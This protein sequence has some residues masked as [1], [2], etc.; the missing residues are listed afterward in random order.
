MPSD[1]KITVLTAVY[2]GERYMREAIDSILNQTYKNFEYILVDNNSTDNTPKILSDYAQRDERIKIVKET[3]QSPAYARNAGLQVATGEW[4]AIFDADDVSHPERLERQYNYMI[5]HPNCFF[6][7]TEG[8]MIGETGKKLKDIRIDFK[9]LS[10]KDYV[11][12]YGPPFIHS[13]MMFSKQKVLEFGGYNE[14]YKTVEDLELWLKI[15]YSGIEINVLRESLINYRYHP[16]SL[17]HKSIESLYLSV[18]TKALYRAKDLGNIN[19]NSKEI[20]SMVKRDSAI[21]SYVQSVI[22]RKKLKTMIDCFI[23][24]DSIKGIALFTSLVFR[25]HPALLKP[26][27]LMPIIDALLNKIKTLD[28]NR[29]N[30][31]TTS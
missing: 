9:G 27:Q 17:S 16:K 13:S 11:L 21:N 6:L 30:D 7:A 2:N 31:D 28:G 5:S 24:G 25:L 23:S 3:K 1:P 20:E 19:V 12:N 22:Y 14:N 26:V 18:I 10:Q 8:V 4:I 15:L 29:R